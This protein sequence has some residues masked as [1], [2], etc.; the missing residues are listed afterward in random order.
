VAGG[1]ILL[2]AERGAR[3]APCVKARLPTQSLGIDVALARSIGPPPPVDLRLVGV[4][5]LPDRTPRLVPRR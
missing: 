5:T 2:V 3:D 1:R 4:P